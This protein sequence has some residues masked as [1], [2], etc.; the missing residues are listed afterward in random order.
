MLQRNHQ[1]SN[2]LLIRA[3]EATPVGAQTYSKSYRYFCGDN[4]PYFLEKGDGAVVWDVDNNTYVD[5]ILGLGAVTVGY[6]NQ[7][8]NSAITRQLE[9]GISFSQAT[10]QEIE[11]A[12]K[13][14]SII[15]CAE[16]VRFLKNGGDATTAAVKLARAATGR[17]IVAA[18]GYH[19][20]H[21]WYICSTTNNRGIPSQLGRL[22]K[23]FEYND[24]SSLERL[25]DENPKKIAAVIL[26]PVQD[27][28]PEGQF[29]HKVKELCNKEGALLI[30]DE[31]ISGFRVALG[32]AQEKYNV[33]PDLAAYGKGM[34][35]GLPISVV[36][37]K[38]D[39]LKLIEEGI[40]ISTTFGGEALSIAGSLKT[41]EILERKDSFPHILN[42]SERLYQKSV[43]LVE[44]KGLSDIITMWGLP[45][46]SGF[47]FAD[48][49]DLTSN[50]LLSVYQ[51][52][53][54]QN[55]ILSLGINNFCLFHD[56]KQ[57]D[58]HIEAVAVALDSVKKALEDN[59]VAAVF[60]G[61]KID[62]IFKRN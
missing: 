15:P 5:F 9:R 11:L 3:K 2:D 13:L 38:K 49:K 31:V 45:V 33:V 42:V 48:Y 59:S 35:N 4:A 50:D 23:T 43:Q 34:G 51:N 61:G 29:L 26:E 54:L 10:K 27:N 12:E 37:G 16:M 7:E 22:T 44:E 55:G 58:R 52:S 32:G 46:H 1:N 19:G 20:M 41:I 14:I 39:I 28:G 21:D 53:L 30:Y 8:V 6:N 47:Q 24:I 18:C 25:F 36:V 17:D 60:S 62:P 40:F 56:F 57:V